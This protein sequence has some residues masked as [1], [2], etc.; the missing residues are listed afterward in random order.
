MSLSI[1]YVSI[2]PLPGSNIALHEQFIKF[3]HAERN[4]GGNQFFV[5]KQEIKSLLFL[6][7][8]YVTILT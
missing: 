1:R 6:L 3:I 4:T 8:A 7:L 2:G 5:L